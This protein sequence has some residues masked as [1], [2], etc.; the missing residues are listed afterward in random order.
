MPNRNV[1]VLWAI[2]ICMN[3]RQRCV[4]VCMYVYT[5]L[6]KYLHNAL[7]QAH[8]SYSAQRHSICRW[9][10]VARR[11]PKTLTSIPYGG[12]AT[13]DDVSF[14]LVLYQSAS[15]AKKEMV[16]YLKVDRSFVGWLLMAQ[17]WWPANSEYMRTS[18]PHCMYSA[19]CVSVFERSQSAVAESLQ[20][21]TH[22]TAEQPTVWCTRRGLIQMFIQRVTFT[23]CQLPVVA[24]SLGWLAEGCKCAS[25]LT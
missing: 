23:F 8:K 5:L 10:L 21:Y 18:P 14:F 2:Y 4:C 1:I 25:G 15:A 13:D 22:R 19:K 12:T 20:C 24:S 17:R 16:E 3:V 7:G 6:D 9:N 11:P